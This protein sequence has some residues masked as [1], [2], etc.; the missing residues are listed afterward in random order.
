MDLALGVR[1]ARKH[2]KWYLANWDW[3]IDQE[4]RHKLSTTDCINQQSRL[5]ESVLRSSSYNI[6]KTT[7]AA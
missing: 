7:Q 4:S 6:S 1:L 5:L 3:A 2:I